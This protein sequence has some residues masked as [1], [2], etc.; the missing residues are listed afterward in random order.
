MYKI[1]FLLFLFVVLNCDSNKDSDTNRQDLI[2]DY[3]STYQE[4]TNIDKF[5]SFYDSEIIL[6]DMVNGDR[7]SGIRNLKEFFDWKN[8]DF[9]LEDSVALV[10]TDQAVLENRVFTQ[11]Y[12]T[13]FSW[14]GTQIQAMQFFTILYLNENGKI[15]RQIDWINYPSY[16][17]DYAERENSN[18]WINNN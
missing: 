14:S 10:I 12:F 6:E 15:I 1:L 9:V 5:L 2:N 7:I 13:P 11:G 16:I 17:V 18:D 4:R 3:Y 8:P